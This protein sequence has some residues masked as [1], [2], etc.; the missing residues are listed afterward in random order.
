M[1]QKTRLFLRTVIVG[2][3]IGTLAVHTIREVDLYED[4]LLLAI[5]TCADLG[6]SFNKEIVPLLRPKHRR[7]LAAMLKKISAI[8]IL[9]N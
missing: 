7:K 4:L 2:D 6:I 9:R 1:K 5:D 8:T 3:V